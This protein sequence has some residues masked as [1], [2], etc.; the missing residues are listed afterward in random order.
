MS[1]RHTL[2]FPS[3]FEPLR[4]V[5]FLN[6]SPFVVSLSAQT[7][8]V[9]NLLTA[10]IWWSC[11]L[12][13]MA[14]AVDPFSS[15]FAIIVTPYAPESS[16]LLLF[17]P[18]HPTPLYVWPVP[19]VQ[20]EDLSDPREPCPTTKRLSAGLCFVY[21]RQKNRVPAAA[22]LAYMT[23]RKEIVRIEGVYSS[24]VSSVKPLP[25]VAKAKSI[26]VF[27]KIY[28]KKYLADT[29]TLQLSRETLSTTSQ[30]SR[31]E[32][33]GALALFAAPT[34]LLPT[35]SKLFL[36]FMSCILG[37]AAIEV[38]NIE[39]ATAQ[40]VMVVSTSEAFNAKLLSDDEI[41]Q[42]D[43]LRGPFTLFAEHALLEYYHSDSCPFEDK[44]GC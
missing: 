8:Y 5:S 42:Q 37:P 34:H 23:N 33:R 9:W 40:P 10:S 24:L 14:L 15:H 41:F 17:H 27:E 7:L 22:C 30:V 43:T 38:P 2:L 36:P 20:I 16:Q 44:N 39:T 31:S 26:S 1:L 21:P 4:T 18:R 19:D 25:I 6:E 12:P 32:S 13:V 28:G 3:P 35:M 11:V 29:P